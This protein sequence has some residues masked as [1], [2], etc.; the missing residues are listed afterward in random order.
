M[1]IS[2]HCPPAGAHVLEAEQNIRVIKERIRITYYNTPFKR[3]PQLMN[4]MMVL[5]AVTQLNLVPA[6]GGVS[7]YFSPHTIMG[8]QPLDLKKHC[9][10]GFGTYVQANQDND[11]MNTNTPQTIDGIYLRPCWNHH[12][13][14]EIMNLEM[15][16]LVTRLLKYLDVWR[17]VS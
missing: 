11:P 1:D 17:I 8:H 4:Q 5:N 6:K 14:H 10:Y 13:G 15:G 7:K 16:E 3:C 2:I 12:R 9:K